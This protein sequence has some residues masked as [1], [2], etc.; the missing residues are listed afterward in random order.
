MPSVQ[1]EYI[2]VLTVLMSNPLVLTYVLGLKITGVI[3]QSFLLFFFPRNPT[4]IQHLP[5]RD[6]SRVFLLLFFS[7]SHK[8]TT[9]CDFDTILFEISIYLNQGQKRAPSSKSQKIKNYTL[10]MKSMNCINRL[11]SFIP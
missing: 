5:L 8:A 7:L 4:F 6:R 10:K 9:F 2:E 1:V 3:Q 11:L